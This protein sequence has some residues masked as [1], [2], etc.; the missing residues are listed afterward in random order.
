MNS[1]H[2]ALVMAIFATYAVN[3]QILVK[4]G[5]KV[6]NNNEIPLAFLAILNSNNIESKDTLL[7]GGFALSIMLHEITGQHRYFI[8][9]SI[10]S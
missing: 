8:K 2:T 5:K 4:F 9:I 7:K 10:A 3:Q 1:W 6:Y